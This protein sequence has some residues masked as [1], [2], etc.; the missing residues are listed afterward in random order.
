MVAAAFFL[1]PLACGGAPVSKTFHGDDYS[2]AYP[3]NW[4]EL[5]KQPEEGPRVD[6][7]VGPIADF[8]LV[9]VSHETGPTAFTE[10]S[11][12]AS[13]GEIAAQA[14]D[15]ANDLEGGKVT[16]RPK[17]RRLAG[18]PGYEAEVA[19]ELE[20]SPLRMLVRWAWDGRTQY[21]VNCQF[22]DSDL[23]QVMKRGCEQ[24]LSSFRVE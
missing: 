19:G 24:I 23:E 20:G 14:R 5:G 3:G 7:A 2:F 8:D 9:S 6:V 4:T 18:L 10:A 12:A 15:L 22:S 17:M 21:Q 16:A 1:A 13:E 11:L